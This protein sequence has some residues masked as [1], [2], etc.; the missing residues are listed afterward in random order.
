ML[1][2]K[3]GCDPNVVTRS[4]E[5]PL[6]YACR[7]GHIDVV[8]L[9]IE[10]YGCNPNVVTKNGESLLH[11]ACR[12]GNIDIVKYFINK[13]HLNPLMTNT[14]NQLEALDYA[15]NNKQY[16]IAAYLCQ[17][18]ISSDEILNPSRIKRTIN[19]IKCIILGANTWENSNDN[20]I[21]SMWKTADG[22]NIFQLSVGIMPSVVVT[23]LLLV[24]S[25]STNCIIANFKPDLRTADGDTI[26]QLVCQSQ[27]VLSHISSTVMIKFMSDSTN[28]MTESV[29]FV[30]LLQLNGKT[31][32]GNNLLEL[33]CQSDKCLAQIPS[34]LFSGW[35]KKTVLRSMTIAIP[36]SKTADGY[37]LLQLILQSQTSISRVSTRMLE[38]LLSNS[39]KITINEMKN[40]N[41]N[42]KTWDGAHFPHALCLSSIENDKVIEL[43]QYYI[44][45]NG[46]NPDT[47]DDK[48]LCVL[49]IACYTDKLDLIYYLIDQAKCNPNIEN[50][51]GSL[52]ID[53]TTSL[54]VSNYLCQHDQVSI[55]SKM[56]IKWLNNP[57]LIDDTK[58]LCS[59]LQS[60]VDNHKTTTKDGSTLLHVICTCRSR[61][62]K[63]LVDYLLTECQCDPNCLDSNGQMPLQLT[64]DS[65]IMNTLVKHGAKM[66]TDVVFNM[67]SSKHIS[68]SNS[69]ELLALSS[70]K[71][72]MLW[73]PTDLNRD[74][75]TAL[76]LAYSCDKQDV[77]NYLLTCYPDENN[78]LLKLTTNLNVARLLIK[79]GARVTPELVLRLEAMETIPNKGT[80]LELM[81]TT[82]NPDDRD[83]DGYTAL[84]LASKATTV[85]LLL[86]VAHCDP[87]IKGGC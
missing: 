17:H 20:P 1:I 67:M 38:K 15:I 36:D 30:L 14:I 84:H 16:S 56:I 2:E 77:V 87:N 58:M 8:K 83:S 50:R 57:L 25:H 24:S 64:S 73:H 22:D 82:W 35:L 59:M 81:L 80:L 34:T 47:S 71:G 21:D 11:Y 9:L 28:L 48:G 55:S 13:H 41:P 76:D 37:T 19:L 75:E 39:R 44:L 70:K 79:H 46:W 61:D 32:D 29:I 63:S 53:M 27:K 40:V 10:K 62:K 66:T 4:D 6:H 72:T 65:E 74:G 85:K 3:Y 54:E 33:I 5:C 60:L 43:M 49:H 69:I 78:L 45:E 51:K 68:E 86:S 7:C 42:W 12:C 31:A 18:F 26:L 23:L 52:P